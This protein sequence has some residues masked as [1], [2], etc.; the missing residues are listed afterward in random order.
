MC[1]ESFGLKYQMTAHM[2]A[3]AYW[4]LGPGVIMGMEVHHWC[5]QMQ[6][7]ASRA[8]LR[9]ERNGKPLLDSVRDEGLSRRRLANLTTASR[10]S[11]ITD[12]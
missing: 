10:P 1:V 12:S 8:I 5:V 7:I 4:T 11:P 9:E 3:H 6:V 2:R